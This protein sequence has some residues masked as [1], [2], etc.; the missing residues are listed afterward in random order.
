MRFAQQTIEVMGV[1]NTLSRAYGLDFA[2]AISFA[3]S[4]GG[5]NGLFF[6]LLPEI[7]GIIVRSYQQDVNL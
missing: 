5:A 6:E 1:Q 2:A 3:E 7:E 4:I